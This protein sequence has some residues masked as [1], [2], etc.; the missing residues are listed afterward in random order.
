METQWIWLNTRR[1]REGAGRGNKILFKLEIITQ[2]RRCKESE[3]VFSSLTLTLVIGFQW[4]P[5]KQK[6]TLIFKL[7]KKG[8]IE[9][10]LQ[11]ILIVNFNKQ[12]NNGAI[13]K[14]SLF[15]IYNLETF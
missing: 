6:T 4:N 14:V 7:V 8:S 3:I 9:E 11:S 10:G 2:H 5:K 15:S 1:V 12:Q 13:T